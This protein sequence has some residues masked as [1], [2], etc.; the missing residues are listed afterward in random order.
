MRFPF[1]V[2][3]Y[4]VITFGNWCQLRLFSDLGTNKCY[5]TTSYLASTLSLGQLT[6]A[7]PEELVRSHVGLHAQRTV[8]RGPESGVFLI[9]S[10]PWRFVDYF[11]GNISIIIREDTLTTHILT[12]EDICSVWHTTTK[13]YASPTRGNFRAGIIWKEYVLQGLCQCQVLKEL[14]KKKSLG[15][16]LFF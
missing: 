11:Q 6:P 14:R 15:G 4:N 10:T 5:V 16:F 13:R 2:W 1:K 3:H 8:M 7:H 9:K 12:S